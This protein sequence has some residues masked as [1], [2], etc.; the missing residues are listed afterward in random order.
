MKKKTHP[1]QKM[2]LKNFLLV[3]MVLVSA[4][5]IA[6]SLGTKTPVFA[7]T[8]S[9][10]ATTQTTPSPTPSSDALTTEKLKERIDNVL[11]SRNDQVKGMID[12]ITLKKRGYIGEVERVIEKTVTVKNSKG[13]QILSISPD[14]VIT[15]DNKKATIDDIAVGDWV[16]V[17][18]YMNNQDF[19]LRRLMVFSSSLQPMSFDTVVGSLQ[20]ITKTSATLVPRNSKDAVIYTLGKNTSYQ[21]VNG[22]PTKRENLQTDSQYLLIGSSDGS[23]KTA[24]LLRA[25]VAASPNSS[26]NPTPTAKP[27]IA[28]SSATKK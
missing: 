10:S 4:L 1:S 12:E 20:T 5:L 26:P 28:T 23:T 19:T 21:D 6:L 14:L 25:L 8:A 7:K 11:K 15:K 22:Q 18:G 16:I 27:K 17:L 9:G 2:T 13:T 24:T 3:G